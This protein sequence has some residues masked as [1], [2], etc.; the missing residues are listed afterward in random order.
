M[1]QMARPPER[2][3]PTKVAVAGHPI[4]PM[5]VTFPIAFLSGTLASDLAFLWFADPF[6]ARMSL[7]LVGAGTV[8]GILAGIS[9]TIELLAIAGIRRR[10]AAW[11]HFITAVMLLAISFTNWII[12]IGDPVAAVWP[13]GLYLSVIMMGM[14][15][16]AGWLGG[17]LVFE[18]QVGIVSDDGD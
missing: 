4:H 8:M 2:G 1:E 14:L 13:L 3:T 6:W 5:L 18:H 16:I 12:R 11:S 7:W 10:A 15:A 9:G 17:H